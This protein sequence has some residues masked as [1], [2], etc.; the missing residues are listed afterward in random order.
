MHQKLAE[1]LAVCLADTVTYKFIA[2]GYHWNVK[3]PEFTQFHDFFATLYEDADSAIDPLAENIRK[4]GFDAPFTLEDF[5]SLTCVSVNPVSGDPIEMSSNLYEIN[6]HLKECLT[7]AFDIANACN[8]QGI[9]NFLAE[10]IDQH[11]KWVWQIGTTIG[12]DSTVITRIE[13]K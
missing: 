6:C 12:A 5:A 13:F 9:A 4:L 2:H 1:H 10:R 11:A 3:G 8:E 7:K